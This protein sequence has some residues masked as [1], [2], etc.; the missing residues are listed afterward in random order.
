MRRLSLR[1]FTQSGARIDD[2]KQQF[3]FILF[4]RLCVTV[5]FAGNRMFEEGD[6]KIFKL[7]RNKGKHFPNSIPISD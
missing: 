2:A 7:D 4:H 5:P 1:G 3:Q 6:E